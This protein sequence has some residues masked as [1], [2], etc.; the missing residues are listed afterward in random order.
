MRSVSNGRNRVKFT[1]SVRQKQW[2]DDDACDDDTRSLN[3]DKGSAELDAF[4][5]LGFDPELLAKITEGVRKH[6]AKTLTDPASGRD[7]RRLKK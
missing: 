2:P 1:Q 4:K 7:T 6:E 3:N 5:A